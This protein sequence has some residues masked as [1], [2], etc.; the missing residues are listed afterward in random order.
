MEIYTS[1]TSGIPAK[2]FFLRLRNF[3]VSSIVDTRLHPSSQLAGYAKKDSLE[4]FA[5]ELLHIPYIHEP[6]L[7]PADAELRAYRNKEIDWDVYESQYKQLLSGRDLLNKIDL[8][9]W[10]ERPVILCSE[11]TPEYCH[12]RL[13]ADYLHAHIETVTEITHL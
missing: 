8:S 12:R 4:F 13:A 10:G 3:N 9:Q 6:L 2:R 7:C 5:M 11:E 1:G